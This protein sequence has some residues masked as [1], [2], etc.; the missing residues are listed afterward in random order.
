MSGVAGDDSHA[1]VLLRHGSGRHEL[2]GQLTGRFSAGEQVAMRQWR[3][4]NSTRSSGGLTSSH[5]DDPTSGI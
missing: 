2:D 4:F 3:H 1:T 5:S